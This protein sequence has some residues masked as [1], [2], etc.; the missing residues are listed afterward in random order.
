MCHQRRYHYLRLRIIALSRAIGCTQRGVV[1]SALI[2]SP[3]GRSASW[4]TRC[5]A[6]RKQNVSACPIRFSVSYYRDYRGTWLYF[7][8][9]IATCIHSHPLFSNENRL[10]ICFVVKRISFFCFCF[11][12]SKT[13]KRSRKTEIRKNGQ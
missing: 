7:V 6:P 8:R 4:R 13:K 1:R 12:I 3:P 9:E 5:P 11:Y 10:K 2:C